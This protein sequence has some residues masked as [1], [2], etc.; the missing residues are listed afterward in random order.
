ML[1]TW[2]ATEAYLLESARSANSINMLKQF[3]NPNR[4][5]INAPNWL[6]NLI[7][8]FPLGAAIV[9]GRLPSN[10]TAATPATSWQSTCA[11][12]NKS[13]PFEN[14]GDACM[15]ETLMLL[16]WKDILFWCDGASLLA[17]SPQWAGQSA[18]REED[19]I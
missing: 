13:I 2:N 15:K 6:R 5:K 9:A 16:F 7:A 10:E 18:L 4:V 11:C 12:W 8:C 17:H 14:V 3:Q 19:E 1:A